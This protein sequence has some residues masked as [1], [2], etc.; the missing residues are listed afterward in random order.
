MDLD[1]KYNL[2]G[3][4]CICRFE[5]Y[6]L[7]MTLL[8]HRIKVYSN[9]EVFSTAMLLLSL[10]QV[11]REKSAFYSANTKVLKSGCRFFLLFP[12]NFIL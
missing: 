12:N 2:F 11:F 1:L 5:K 7:G 10:E 9:P 3:L 4:K 6:L 8:G